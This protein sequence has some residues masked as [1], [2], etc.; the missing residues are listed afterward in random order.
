VKPLQR[1]IVDEA[2]RAFRLVFRNPSW[3][4]RFRLVSGIL[5]GRSVSGWF[6][7]SFL[8]DPFQ[9]GFRNPDLG[10]VEWSA[11]TEML[12]MGNTENVRKKKR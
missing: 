2:M 1:Q 8:V 7:E 6:Q 10:T 12:D 5:P 3:S 11:R 9:V 4:I